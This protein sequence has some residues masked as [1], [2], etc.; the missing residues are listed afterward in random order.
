MATPAQPRRAVALVGRSM[1]HAA[2]AG[3]T[4][5]PWREALVMALVCYVPLAT[6]RAGVLNADTKQ[7]LYLDPGGLLERA[8]N[9]WD[10][11]IAGGPVTHQNIGYLCP[12]GPYFWLAERPRSEE[13]R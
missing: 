13:S 1:T 4:E 10:P 2:A 11:T 9:V 12:Q 8:A 7:Y 6:G 5:R 3:R